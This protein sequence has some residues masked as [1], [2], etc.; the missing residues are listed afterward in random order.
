MPPPASELPSAIDKVISPPLPPMAVP[1][2][3]DNDPTFPRL[4][5]PV[6]SVKSPLWPICPASDE[7]IETEPLEDALL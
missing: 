4:L 7:T 2:A 3:R 5:D 6:A 1:T